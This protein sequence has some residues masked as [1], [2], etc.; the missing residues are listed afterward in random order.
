MLPTVL[1]LLNALCAATCF[2][3]L[4]SLSSLLQPVGGQFVHPNSFAVDDPHL[5]S[6]QN[7]INF[8]RSPSSSKGSDPLMPVFGDETVLHVYTVNLVEF[9]LCMLLDLNDLHIKSAVTG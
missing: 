2:V 5:S 8:H 6:D 4:M 7:G 1:V 3:V 9:V